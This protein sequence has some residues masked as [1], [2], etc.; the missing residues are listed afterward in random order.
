MN[1]R[2]FLAA[3]A[4]LATVPSIAAPVPKKKPGIQRLLIRYGMFGACLINEAGK[5][6]QVLSDLNAKGKDRKWYTCLSPDGSKVAWVCNVEV[7]D[8]TV[9]RLCVRDLDGEGVGTV[10]TYDDFRVPVAWEGSTRL[11]VRP[12]APSDEK[13]AE[14]LDVTTGKSKPAEAFKEG[15]FRQASADGK[16]WLLCHRREEGWSVRSADG[17]VCNLEC[18]RKLEYGEVFQAM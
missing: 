9:K 8:G 15:D 1:R 18:G 7:K 10:A 17:K 3:S 6:D 12:V 11:L 5:K 2:Q 14:W 13:P 4:A 16:V